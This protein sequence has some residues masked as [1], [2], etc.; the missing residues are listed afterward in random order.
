MCAQINWQAKISFSMWWSCSLHAPLFHIWQNRKFF[1]N[2]RH[3]SESTI[4]SK[5]YYSLFTIWIFDSRRS[6]VYF[7]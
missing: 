7:L 6:P 2:C 4:C 3:H 1:T 5:Q